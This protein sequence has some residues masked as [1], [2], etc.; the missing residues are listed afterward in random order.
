M[1]FLL[2]PI[3]RLFLMAKACIA[4]LLILLLTGVGSLI[5]MISLLVPRNRQLISAHHIDM[6]LLHNK[7]QRYKAEGHWL[8]K[9]FRGQTTRD[10]YFQP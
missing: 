1:K 4:T 9:N 10:Y 6:V 3:L 8:R 2:T 5:T 7:D